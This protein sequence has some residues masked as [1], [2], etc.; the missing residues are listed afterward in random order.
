[1]KYSESKLNKKGFTL[2]ELLIVV[3]IIAVLVAISI[4]I[5]TK[6]LEKSRDSVTV[7]N[8]RAAY[9]EAAVEALDSKTAS[10]TVTKPVIYKGTQAGFE[11]NINSD[12]PFTMTA[13]LIAACDGTTASTSSAQTVYVDFTF[14][15]TGCAAD[16]GTAPTTTP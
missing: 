11:G 6:Q 10:T 7:A 16:V 13:D 12:L 1:M 8:L 14:S 2:A 5:F 3:A 9:A 15:D 4:P